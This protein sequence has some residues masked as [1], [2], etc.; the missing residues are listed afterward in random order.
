MVSCSRGGQ[1]AAG[2]G[3][4]SG[5]VGLDLA[6][7]E[8]LMSPAAREGSPNWDETAPGRGQ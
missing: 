1:L 2:R 6:A 3:R 8:V 4:A 5:A 7:R